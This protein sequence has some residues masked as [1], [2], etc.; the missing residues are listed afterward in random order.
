MIIGIVQLSEINLTLI[1]KVFG[2]YCIFLCIIFR[3]FRYSLE[4]H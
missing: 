4:S 3:D 2:H 1:S